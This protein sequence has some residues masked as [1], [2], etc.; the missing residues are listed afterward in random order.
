MTQIDSILDELQEIIAR[1]TIAFQEA[2]ALSETIEYEPLQ[3][4]LK[5]LLRRA[6]PETAASEL[7]KAIAQD[8][9]RLETFPEVSVK[10]GG[11]IDFMLEQKSGNPVLLELKP[12]FTLD[13]ADQTVKSEK[14]LYQFHKKQIQKYL[15]AN[16]YVMLTNLR[17]LYLFSREALL[18]YAPFYHTDWITFLRDYLSYDTLWDY[19]RRLEDQIPHKD[20]DQAFFV[21]LK[22]WYAELN[23]VTLHPVNGLSKEEL[24]VLFLNKIIF[25]KTLEDYGLIPFKLLEK[26]YFD[27]R[28]IWSPLGDEETFE[29]FFH[30][31]EAWFYLFYDTD[32]FSTKFWEAVERNPA[33][34]ACFRQK[35]EDVLGFG[36]WQ[37]AFG[38]GMIHYNYRLIDEDVFGKAYETF[39]AENRKDTGIYYTPQPLTR[40]MAE[41]LVASLFDD[42]TTEILQAL[43]AHDYDRA[44]QLFDRLQQIRIIDPCSGSGSFLIKALRAIYA[45]YERIQ[46]VLEQQAADAKH[47]RNLDSLYIEQ[48]AYVQAL[49]QFFKTNGF[50]E[51]LR[52]IGALILRHLYAVDIDD[53]ALETA[54]VNIWKEAIKLHPR[55]YSFTKI[56][57]NRN[58]AL[59]SLDLNFSNGDSLLDPPIAQAVELIARDFKESIR[60]MH[61]IRETYLRNPFDPGQLPEIRQLKNPIIARL[62]QELPDFPKPVFMAVEYFFAYFDRDGNPLPSEQWGFDAVISNPPWEE[63]Y[64]V[65]KEFADIGKYSERQDFEK[66]FNQRLQEDPEFRAGWEKY[67]QFYRA[68]SQFVMD[69]Y[70]FHAMRPEGSK[71]M[72]THLNY[73]KIFVERDLELVK[74]DGM[75]TILIPSSFQTDEGGYGLRNLVIDQYRLLELYSFE[76]RGYKEIVDEKEITVK[77]FPEVHPQFKFSIVTVQKSHHPDGQFNAKFYLLNPAELYTP[78]IQYSAK[79]V[80]NFSPNNLSIMEFRTHEDYVLC[81]KIKSD[82][83]VLKDL[84]WRFRREFNMTD[85]SEM[86]QESKN[87]KTCIVYE[88]KMIHQYNPNFESARYYI[89]ETEG[90]KQLFETLIKRLKRDLNVSQKTLDAFLR[91][92]SLTLDCEDY[93]LVYRDVGS[94]TNERTLIGT[95]LPQQVFTVN[96]LTHLTNFYYEL[97][98]DKIV[99]KHIG[100]HDVVYLMALLNSL[101]L[102]YYIRN[103]ISAH[104]SMFYAY[105]LPI[106]AAT[107]AQKAAIIHH[108]FSLLARNDA[109]G[110]FAELGQALQVTP[111]MSTDPIQLR[112]ALEVL[113]AKD[114]YGLTAAEWQYM[115]STFV[116]GSPT[117]ATRQELDQIIQAANAL[118]EDKAPG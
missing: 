83:R 76:N 16:D 85:D 71:A 113:I 56:P 77:P 46:A 17:E 30:E 72:R 31:I 74:Q 61:A 53:R 102:N 86:F 37:Q 95:I 6:K 73:F 47:A 90:K 100:Y 36:G 10:G 65:K 8:I 96:T 3:H 62:R 2:E 4:Y 94:S 58:H 110:A 98:D 1:E 29:F 27:K 80:K 32:L 55:A 40:Y 38:K 116:Y 101:V 50:D 44:Q 66:I 33:N 13:K 79:M 54:K 67:Q 117:S 7:F 70:T 78:P 64:P 97:N 68:Y 92:E 106:P 99:Q 19:I 114:L 48:P 75:M 35:V 39:L 60:Q 88:G 109:T 91:T 12:L 82:H 24:I 49:D 42:L 57:Q 112:A 23:A 103:K 108:A 11:F 15:A 9:L 28:Y 43:Q 118:F 107:D 115:T 25:I 14:L 84:G 105:E 22:K 18:E 59:P 20:L 104:I 63:I 51:P 34:V 21:D 81:S 69:R 87:D 111:D 89:D 93:K 5:M 52:L 41:Q 45:R 26:Q